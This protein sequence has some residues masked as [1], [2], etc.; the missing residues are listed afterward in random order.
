MLTIKV[1]RRNQITGRWE[2]KSLPSIWTATLH[3]ALT[4]AT[5]FT[6]KPTCPDNKDPSVYS[7]CRTDRSMLLGHVE[8]GGASLSLRVVVVVVNVQD[9][10]AHGQVRG[11]RGGGRLQ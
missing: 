8:I 4:T 9:A 10:E 2:L 7:I 5:K 3:R 11:G 6:S 1:E